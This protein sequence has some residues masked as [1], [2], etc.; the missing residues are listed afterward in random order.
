MQKT[1]DENNGVHYPITTAP[2][3]LPGS[4]VLILPKGII[5]EIL[6]ST[7]PDG[8]F[9][10]TWTHPGADAEDL[11]L[12][13]WGLPL[14]EGTAH[15][16]LLCRAK[17]A[18]HTV[19]MFNTNSSGIKQSSSITRDNNNNSSSS[20][21]IHTIAA[22]AALEE[23]KHIVKLLATICKQN[24]SVA[25]SLL[26]IDIP[27]PEDVVSTIM[28]TDG[29]SNSNKGPNIL[30]VTAD[31]VAG[32]LGM[33]QPPMQLIADCFD[34]M[35]AYTQSVPA[36]VVECLLE[37]LQLGGHVVVSNGGENNNN[38]STVVHHVSF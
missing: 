16:T 19:Q 7:I 6:S 12:V 3:T 17:E 33:D 1:Q 25:V 37:A 13:R 5:G 32:V 35:A 22:H 11:R 10:T 36:Q 27:V 24:T 29:M 26:G 31:V 18:L 14:S 20:S 2:L 28:M 34:I 8:S 4:Q 23:L 38:G 30:T 21:S 9:H 15:L